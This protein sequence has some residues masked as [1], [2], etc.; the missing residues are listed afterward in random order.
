MPFV[1]YAIAFLEW[2]TTL[3]VEIVALRKFTPIIW[4]SS[5]STSI[6]LWV[7][8]LALSYWY[9]KWGQISAQWKKVE[10]TL[11]RNLLLASAYYFFV[12]FIFT[13]FTLQS[14]LSLSWNYFFAI[15]ISSV[16]LFFIPVFLASQTIP[17][18]SELLK[19]KHSWEKMWKLLFYSTIWSFLWSVGTSSFLFPLIWVEKTAIISPL[20]LVICAVMIMYYTKFYKKI[21][22]IMTVVLFSF[23]IAILWTEIKEENYLFH[24]S[25]AYHDIHIYDDDFGRRIFSLDGAYSSGINNSDKKSFFSYITEVEKQVEI[26]KP[27]NILVIWA[28]GFTFP[29]D[30]SKHD[31]IENIDVIDVDKDL[32]EIAEKY[33]L[34]EK[35]S[36]KINFYAQPA[37]YFLNTVEE[38]TYDMVLVDA[39]SW[40][41]LPPQVLTQEFFEQLTTIS[42]EI[43]L[44]I[45]MDTRLESKFSQILLNTLEQ[46]FPEVYYKNVWWN[47]NY[48][49]TNFIITN[50]N[51]QDYNKVKIEEREVY[52]DNKHSIELDLFQLNNEWFK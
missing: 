11:V 30:I 38:K 25:N 7:I 27:K 28:A 24:S 29:R 6:I 16:I 15:L 22:C 32:K 10:S 51:I 31:F 45:I 21:F 14:I 39:Y 44:N 36:D 50:K 23:Y 20:I 8:L 1:I 49:V 34:E 42:D 13:E 41:S 37:R 48:F 9:Y 12:T 40:K 52:T 43:Y 33:F 4:S 2:F 3:S 17:L 19:W 46:S 47:K 18:L 5:I 26:Q 35:L